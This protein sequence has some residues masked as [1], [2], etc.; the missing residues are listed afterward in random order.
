M[1]ERE[2]HASRKHEIDKQQSVWSLHQ[3]KMAE[4][5]SHTKDQN[6]NTTEIKSLEG[7]DKRNKQ[8]SIKHIFLKKGK[9]SG[10]FHL[11]PQ[12]EASEDTHCEAT[13]NMQDQ[14]CKAETCMSHEN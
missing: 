14:I 13:L 5:Q 2:S 8:V 3:S 10:K 12:K 6:A 1:S 9:D 4:L 11:L 7:H